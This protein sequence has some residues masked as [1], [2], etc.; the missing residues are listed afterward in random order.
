MPAPGRGVPATSTT[1]GTASAMSNGG[2]TI[3]QNT[4]LRRTHAVASTQPVS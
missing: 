1:T 3:G 2:A 4:P